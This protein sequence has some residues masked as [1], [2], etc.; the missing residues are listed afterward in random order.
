MSFQIKYPMHGY[1]Y[2]GVNT[3]LGRPAKVKCDGKSMEL[4]ADKAGPPI[5]RLLISGLLW[6]KFLF[7]THICVLGLIHG[8]KSFMWM[9]EH[10]YIYVR[11]SGPKDKFPFWWK[12]YG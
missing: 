9:K 11:G 3:N 6:I 4:Y 12:E 8:I 2:A 1:I 7:F 10:K 5:V